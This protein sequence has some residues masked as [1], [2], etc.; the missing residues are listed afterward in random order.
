MVK[1]FL[2]GTAI[3][4]FVP[5]LRN[6]W[7]PISLCDGFSLA[8]VLLLSYGGVLFLR[9]QQA[10]EGVFYIGTRIKNLLFPFLTKPASKEYKYQRQTSN[11]ER[12]IDGSALVIGAGFLLISIGLLF[13]I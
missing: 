12:K 2:F 13:F 8:G 11:I 10:F 3:T 5:I 1:Y 9:N 4:L 6:E 7:T